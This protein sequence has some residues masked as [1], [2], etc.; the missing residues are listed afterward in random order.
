MYHKIV[1]QKK[2]KYLSMGRVIRQFA[3]KG[4]KTHEDDEQDEGDT[5]EEGQ[6]DTVDDV[7]HEFPLQ[8]TSEMAGNLKEGRGVD[9]SGSL[10]SSRTR[11]IL[12]E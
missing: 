2:N 7:G 12:A 1:K 6:E 3:E 9:Q 10:P 5:G 11:R 4:I 8:S